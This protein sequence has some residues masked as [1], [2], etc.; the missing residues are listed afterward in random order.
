MKKTI[1]LS[2]FIIFGF[3]LSACSLS[4]PEPDIIPDETPDIIPDEIPD[5]VPEGTL[6]PCEDCHAEAEI[7]DDWIPIWCDEFDG[8][9]VDVNKWNFEDQPS[10]W[11]EEVQYYS[12]NNIFTEDGKL[13][14]EAR[15][16][17]LGGREYTSGR[18]HTQNKGD[19]LYGRVIVRAKMPTG[20][21]SWPAIWMIPTD[22]VYGNWPLSGEIDIM[23]YVGYDQNKIHG[24][25]H[26]SKYNWMKSNNIGTSVMV[27]NVEERFIDYEMIWKPGSISLYVDGEFLVAYEYIASIEK[28]VPYHQAWP[29]DQK[30]YLV[31]NLALG[32]WGGVQGIDD[33]AFPM[34]YEIDYVRVYQR[35]YPYIDSQ[36]PAPID[37]VIMGESIFKS[38]IYWDVPDDDYGIEYYEIFINNNLHGTSTVNSFLV[39][40][41]FSRTKYC[42]SVVAVDFAG[43]KSEPVPIEFSYR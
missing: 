12:P 10:P 13:I 34:R 6:F 15:K 26:T 40:G 31:L 30:F 20:R 38:M 18:M 28:N 42:L 32:G 5:K 16:E 17:S 36:A 21:G 3:I 8:D 33:E 25:F 14:I 23:E 7:G 11:N 35:D 2:L 9:S 4:T 43:H 39:S 1:F 29:F 24:N 41:L 27:E 19:W 22:S 37:T